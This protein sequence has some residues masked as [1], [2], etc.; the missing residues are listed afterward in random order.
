MAGAASELLTESAVSKYR[1][2]AAR[3]STMGMSDMEAKLGGQIMG[4]CLI[5]ALL[6][7]ELVN[8]LARGPHP[9][10]IREA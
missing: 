9:R 10:P 3:Q 6:T 8:A 4:Y 2:P 5:V 7:L 1:K